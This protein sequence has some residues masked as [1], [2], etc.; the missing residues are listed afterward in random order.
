M[1]TFTIVDPT[2]FNLLTQNLNLLLFQQQQHHHRKIISAFGTRG[3]GVTTLLNQT[4]HSTFHVE[5]VPTLTATRG[6][7]A[8]PINLSAFKDNTDDVDEGVDKESERG[9]VF[10]IEGFESHKERFREEA[11]HKCIAFAMSVSESLIW[12]IRY[13][14]IIRGGSAD[15]DRFMHCVQ[16]YLE[17]FQSENEKEGSGREKEGYVRKRLVV[18]V[19]DYEEE[20]VEEKEVEGACLKLFSEAY[21]KIKKGDRFKGMDFGDV[22]EIGFVMM[23]H[24]RLKKDGFE[25][26]CEKIRRRVEGGGKKKGVGMKEEKEEKEK[27]LEEWTEEVNRIWKRLGAKKDESVAPEKE[28]QASFACDKILNKVFEQYKNRS[29][30]WKMIVHRGRI[31]RNFGSEVQKEIDEASAVFKRDAAAY[32][33][34]KAFARKKSELE[35]LMLGEAYVSYSMQLGALKEIVHDMFRSKL[36]RTRISGKVEKQVNVAIKE[37]E[38]YFVEQAQSLRSIG[39]NWRYDRE[40][41]SLVDRMRE[42]ATERLQLA[43]IHGSYVPP[44]RAPVAVAFHTLLPAPFGQDARAP[45]PVQQEV[46][47][48]DKNRL[49]RPGFTRFRPH[50]VGRKIK[51][52]EA[53]NINDIND[54]E[55]VFE[56]MEDVEE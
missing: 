24:A 1:S 4:F 30:Q 17:I 56:G 31:I 39:S 54:F 3:S 34:T 53:Y 2:S 44:I 6:I 29:S 27:G 50:Q 20:E 28:V 33:N 51:P 41:Q 35:E 7:Q 52:G 14:D 5:T 32:K 46:P 48:P 18:V 55:D 43:R 47:K 23:P 16:N 38:Q 49:L 45:R 37:C 10:D 36:A 8:Q 9:V 12:C 11:Q 19:K 40:R 25:K 42:G 15:I 22:F 21:G 26:G 13:T